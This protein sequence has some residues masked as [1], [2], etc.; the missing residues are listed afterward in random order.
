VYLRDCDLDE[1]IDADDSILIDSDV[2]ALKKCDGDFI[3]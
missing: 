2:E 1:Y 3:E